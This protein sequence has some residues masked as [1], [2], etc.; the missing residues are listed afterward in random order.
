VDLCPSIFVNDQ[1]ER[2][3]Y[4]SYVDWPAARGLVIKIMGYNM[5][6]RFIKVL[7]H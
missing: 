6:A 2:H 5:D 1:L 4:Q 7:P 3:A